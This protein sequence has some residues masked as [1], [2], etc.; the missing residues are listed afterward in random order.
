V[1]WQERGGIWQVLLLLGH[2]LLAGP[3]FALFSFLWIVLFMFFSIGTI[4]LCGVGLGLLLFT[5]ESVRMLAEAELWMA[6]QICEG[7]S[8]T[9]G[10]T[11]TL[12]PLKTRAAQMGNMGNMNAS[13]SGSGSGAGSGSGSSTADRFQ[14]LQFGLMAQIR[15]FSTGQTWQAVYYLSIGS[16]PI[17][18]VIFG[19]GIAAVIVSAFLQLTFLFCPWEQRSCLLRLMT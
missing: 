16:L 11:Y 7:Q 6:N 5:L 14:A 13:G 1:P 8:G 10:Q 3:A 19:L 4:P 2:G 18:F 9:I 12:K 17:V 15:A